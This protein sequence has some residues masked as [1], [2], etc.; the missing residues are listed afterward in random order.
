MASHVRSKPTGHFITVDG[1]CLIDAGKS[2]VIRDR[3][4][5]DVLRDFLQLANPEATV[6]AFEVYELTAS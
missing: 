1:R 6:R 3:D 2:G 4:V 5:A